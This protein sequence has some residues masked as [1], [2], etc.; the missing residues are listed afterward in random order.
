MYRRRGGVS[1][2]Y[3]P[4]GTLTK[5][6]PK[7]TVLPSAFKCPTYDEENSSRSFKPLLWSRS[8][9]RHV[10]SGAKLQVKQESPQVHYLLT[11]WV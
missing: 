3:R 1:A 11:H 5:F 4:P 6:S 7:S 10:D 9:Q 2:A 8:V